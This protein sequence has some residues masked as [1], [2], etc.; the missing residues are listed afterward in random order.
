MFYPDHSSV[1]MRK[2]SFTAGLRLI[3]R[4]INLSKI[5]KPSL[6]KS[7]PTFLFVKRFFSH[8]LFHSKN[9]HGL[10]QLISTG[11]FLVQ[12]LHLHKSVPFSVCRSDF[13]SFVVMAIPASLQ[14]YHKDSRVGKSQ[15]IHSVAA[16][17]FSIA[18]SRLCLTW[19]AY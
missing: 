18:S 1:R 4:A 13:V 6:Q 19:V 9:D 10:P 15:Y 7:K 12:M 8:Q 16:Q 3:Y 17:V 5:S 2:P 14:L 11:P